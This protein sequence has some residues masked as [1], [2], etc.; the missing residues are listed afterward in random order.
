MSKVKKNRKM[1][2]EASDREDARTAQRRSQKAEIFLPE[3]E[4]RHLR[5]I[6]KR[7]DAD[8]SGDLDP[9][10]CSEVLADLGLK[11]TTRE[12]KLELAEIMEELQAGD[13]DIDFMQLCLIVQRL[14]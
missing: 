11:P 12:E 3:A 10:E 2:L 6:C 8:G 4:L 14:R 5:E 13:G 9:K 7:Y 1:W